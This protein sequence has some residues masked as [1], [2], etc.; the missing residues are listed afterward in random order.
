MH[1]Y[2]DLGQVDL[3]AVIASIDERGAWASSAADAVNTYYGRPDVQLAVN[4]GQA[5][6]FAGDASRFTEIIG[7][8]AEQYGHDVSAQTP[9]EDAVTA[10]R[11]LLAKQADNSVDIVVIGW[12]SNMANLMATVANHN[13]DGI[14]KT[15]KELLEQKVKRLVV[16]GGQYPSGSEFNFELDGPS[17]SIVTAELDVPTIFTGYELG[18]LVKSGETLVNTPV[19]NPVREAYKL[20]GRGVEPYNRA[21]WDL[22][23]VVYAVE[24]LSDYF[25]YSEP[26]KN[27]VAFDGSNQWLAGDEKAD[28]YL[29]LKDAG[30]RDRLEERLNEILQTP[31]LLK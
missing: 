31:P 3:L 20:Y 6:A 30:A 12:M 8:D 11:R 26:G 4:R 24:G 7:A 10:Y 13:G 14:Q 18:T 9:L 16:M 28:R 23:A 15:G 2:A 5:T 27:Q 19:D 25:R 29:E 21:S 1:Y 22:S 17:A